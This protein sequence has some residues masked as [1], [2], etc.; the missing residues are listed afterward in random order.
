MENSQCITSKYKL[1]SMQKNR[2]IWPIRKRKVNR[3]DPEVTQGIELVDKDIKMAT[4]N[5]L[6]MLK[7][8]K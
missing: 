1:P 4:I 2:E 8:I 7:K 6:Q 3:R 5:L